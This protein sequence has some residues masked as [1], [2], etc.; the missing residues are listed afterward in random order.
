MALTLVKIT[1]IF[2]EQSGDTVALS[3]ASSNL[4]PIYLDD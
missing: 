1:A 2:T 3:E 4:P